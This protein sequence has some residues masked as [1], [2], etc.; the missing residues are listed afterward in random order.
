MCCIVVCRVFLVLYY[1]VLLRSVVCCNM[2]LCVAVYCCFWC[3]L[4]CVVSC[5]VRCFLL[6]CRDV[7]HT[8]LLCRVLLLA[9]LW[10]C[11]CVRDVVYRC[12]AM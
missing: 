4:L 10:C 11:A 3:V 7:C 8:V 2:L 6:I 1:E 12:F 9:V 5:F